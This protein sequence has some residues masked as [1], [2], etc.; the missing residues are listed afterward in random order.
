MNLRVSLKGTDEIESCCDFKILIPSPPYALLWFVLLFFTLGSNAGAQVTCPD[1]HND[2]QLLV[3][4]KGT[5]DTTD[6]LNWAA[7]LDTD[8]WEG[9]FYP[10]ISVALPGSQKLSLK[11]TL[12]KV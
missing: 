6:V 8:S 12:W 7:D 3:D 1:P 4:I 11:A 2:K 9:D 10:Q 5:L